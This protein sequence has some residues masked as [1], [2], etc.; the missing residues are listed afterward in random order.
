MYGCDYCGRFIDLRGALAPRESATMS[1]NLI[2]VFTLCAATL[3]LLL[4]GLAFHTGTIRGFLEKSFNNPED[5]AMGAGKRE[6][7][8][9]PKTQRWI[10]AHRNAMENFVPF[11]VLGYLLAVQLEHSLFWAWAFVIY[12]GLR[13]IHAV[14]YI[15]AKQPFRT[16]S[17]A[18]GWVVMMMMAGKLI[19]VAVG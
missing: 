16:L 7:E 13:I 10:R 15:N 5:A 11:A 2:Q 9:G 3:C 1:T 12:T 8:D 14:A 6:G 4:L 18:G 17:F 19:M